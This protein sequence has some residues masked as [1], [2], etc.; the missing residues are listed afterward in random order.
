MSATLAS[1]AFAM[2]MLTQVPP[3]AASA[4]RDRQDRLRFMKEKAAEFTL[5]RE[6]AKE[7]LPLKE[8]PIVRFSIPERDNG[9]WDGATFLWLEG[10]RP[11]AAL[12]LGIRRPDNGLFFEHTSFSSTPL[13][14]RRNESAMWSPQTGGLLSQ[15]L[16]GAP[17]PAA[18]ATGRL[19]Q[20]RDLA[21]RFSA[22]CYWGTDVTH[23]RL[24]PQPLYRYSDAKEGIL[25]GALFS[26]V[27]SNDPEMFVLLEAVADPMTG[28]PTWRY[29][30]ARM[31]SLKHTVNLDDKEVWSII[32][33][34]RIPPAERKTG[35]YIEGRMGVYTPKAK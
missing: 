6:S 13:V 7:P 21:R 30:L 10:A 5:Y 23:L 24:Q 34:Y 20:M 29:S 11:V 31:S 32:G 15:E 9:V 16:E 25:D 18:T 8:D 1:L 12:S 17:A 2:T 28:K 4:D 14:C 22:T 27:V 19:T 3:E 33:F 26:M 35:P